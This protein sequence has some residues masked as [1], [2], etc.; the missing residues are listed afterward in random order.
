MDR[1]AAF[2]SQQHQCRIEGWAERLEVAD[3]FIALT[4][5]ELLEKTEAPLLEHR[6]RE[7]PPTVALAMF[8]KQALSLHRS[9]QRVVDRSIAECVAGGLKVHS[10]R[11]GEYC[12]VRLRDR[13]R[14]SRHRHGKRGRL[15]RPARASCCWRGPPVKLGD[16]TGVLMPHTKEN[17]SRWP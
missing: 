9:Y 7:Y 15:C 1:S 13:C 8:L 3:F 6:E 14:W 17:P 12:R 10:A 2:H 4:G 16:G 5:P 11:T